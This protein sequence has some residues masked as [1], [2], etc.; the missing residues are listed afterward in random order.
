MSLKDTVSC[1]AE[2]ERE[3]L[4]EEEFN[5]LSFQDQLGYLNLIRY[6]AGLKK[7][8]KAAS[9]IPNPKQEAFHR[10]QA[11]TRAIFGGNRS[12]KTTAGGLEFLWH[13]TGVYP[14]WYPKDMQFD[15]PVKG[16][17]IASDYTQGV[18]SV[19]IPF[20]EEWLDMS[21]IE[22]K[23]RN[24]IGVYTK[25]Y[26][27]NGNQFDIVTHEQ[28]TKSF[29]GW[30]GDV[31]WFDEPPPR[32]KYI[33]T[34]RGL[35]DNGGRMWLTLTPLN[36]PWIYDDVYKKH[37]GVNVFVTTMSMRDNMVLSEKD[38]AE[39][40]GKL[41][42]DE[43]SARMEGAFMHLVGRVYKQFRNEV[44]LCEPFKIPPHW[45]RYMCVD[46]HP[47]K[48]TAVLW[49]AVDE[50]ENH[51]LYD[52]LSFEGDAHQMANMI[53]AQEGMMPAHQRFIDP[54][55]DKD[56]QL[57]GGMNVRKE[58][59][60]YGVYC[61]RANNDFDLGFNR[62]CESLRLQYSPLLAKEISRLKVFNTCKNTIY[63]FEHY[64]WGDFKRNPEEHGPK[65]KVKKVHDDFM[66]CLRYIYNAG[67]RYYDVM[68]REEETEVVYAGTFA[69]YP[70][71]QQSSSGSA[72]GYYDLV[73][74]E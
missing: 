39:F 60:K 69:K 48:P 17:I 64:M 21:M 32:D 2:M 53:H 29:E 45:V 4:T 72:K 44:H 52:E 71:K 47:R 34:A 13:M 38:I 42:A 61:Q 31:A 7:Q 14:D 43:K 37:D 8:V 30:K 41:N 12:G 10:S 3:H 62:I 40:E 22:R 35:I 23:T 28:D 50:Q 70:T 49:L 51:Y 67:P 33:A 58:L 11:P 56:N 54:A 55:M 20:L 63:E 5:Q 1:L 59:A 57:F 25:W 46:P 15:R 6:E 65:E 9:Y 18:G 36:Q 27:R 16:R 74:K 26:L 68:G 73:E 66:D 24:P 19:I